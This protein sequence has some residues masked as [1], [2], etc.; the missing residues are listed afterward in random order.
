VLFDQIIL[1]Y[2]GFYFRGGYH[3]IK[4]SYPVHHSPYLGMQPFGGLEIGADPV[5]QYYG[6]THIDDLSLLIFKNI[7][8]RL[9]GQVF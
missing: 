6:F 9:L 2:Q 3:I 7:D 4:V 1:Q 8:S 5:P